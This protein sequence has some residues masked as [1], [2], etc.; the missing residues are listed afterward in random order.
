MPKTTLT[1]WKAHITEYAAGNNIPLS[2]SKI[3]RLANRINKRFLAYTD[4]DLG[5]ILQYSDPTATTAIRN[6]MSG[7]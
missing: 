2:T 1:G 6:V 5:K 4:C 3:S 7:A